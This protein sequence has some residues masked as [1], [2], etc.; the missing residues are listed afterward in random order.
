MVCD[1]TIADGV[2]ASGVT[3]ACCAGRISVPVPPRERESSH[4]VKSLGVYPVRAKPVDV[5]A[6]EEA[7]CSGVFLLLLF[8]VG[9]VAV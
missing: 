9:R 5:V 7:G 8:V 1:G 6:T 4:A 2:A 3:E